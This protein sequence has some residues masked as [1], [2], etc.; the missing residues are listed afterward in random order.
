[1]YSFR[2][3]N[4]EDKNIRTE[5]RGISIEGGVSTERGYFD[6][7]RIFRQRNPIFGQK[8]EPYLDM[9]VKLFITILEGDPQLLIRCNS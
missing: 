6:R 4:L 7:E 5:I 3:S 1:M 2:C 9:R 8:E